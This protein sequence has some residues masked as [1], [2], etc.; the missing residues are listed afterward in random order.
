MD[1]DDNFL[2]VRKFRDFLNQCSEGS[3]IKQDEATRNR[4]FLK[5]YLEAQSKDARNEQEDG[6]GES[7]AFNDVTQ[8]WSYAFQV[9]VN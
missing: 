2:G 7:V 5:V 3:D 1:T 4:K 9:S 6:T 8:I